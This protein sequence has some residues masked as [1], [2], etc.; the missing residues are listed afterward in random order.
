M[1]Q[2][3]AATEDLQ[4]E[5]AD[6]TEQLGE[7]RERF[8][9]QDLIADPEYMWDAFLRLPLATQRKLVDLMFV[10]IVFVRRGPRYKHPFGGEHVQT[11]LR[12]QKKPP[13]G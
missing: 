12:I 10:S 1:A 8:L 4:R 11:D 7:A 9:V 13:A 6:L 2:V 5:I 3:G